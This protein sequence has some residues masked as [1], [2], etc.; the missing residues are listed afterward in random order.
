MVGGAWPFL[1]G[2]RICL[3]NF[4][5]ERDLRYR[6]YVE[7]FFLMDDFLEELFV[8]NA[9]KFEAKNTSAIPF[10][11]LGCTRATLMHSTS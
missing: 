2:G 9:R 3:L 11:V 4:V 10:D 6:N 7:F 8:S 5:S 1:V